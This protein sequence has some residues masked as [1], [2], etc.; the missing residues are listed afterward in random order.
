MKQKLHLLARKWVPFIK[1]SEKTGAVGTLVWILKNGKLTIKG[2]GAMPNCNHQTTWNLYSFSITSI[3]IENGVT[4][5][6]D[7]AFYDCIHLS[8]ITIPA[9]V[10]TIGEAAFSGCTRLVS[11]SIPDSV[12][13]IGAR[14][15]S[16]CSNL[17]SINIPRNITYIENWTFSGCNRLASIII[18]HGVT[19]IGSCAFDDCCN[20]VSVT[21]PESV[22]RIKSQAFSGCNKLASVIV[23]WQNPLN[24]SSDIFNQINLFNVDL[25]IPN[26]T[27]KHYRSSP[28]WKEFRIKQV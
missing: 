16:D 13:S 20:L 9:S 26:K 7:Y 19:G 5:I 27:D 25:I 10:K 22:L 8:S 3:I 6:G 14:A 12:T 18:P 2:V 11:I 21:I 23:Q 17:A 24:I 4:A 28:V 15:F 1:N